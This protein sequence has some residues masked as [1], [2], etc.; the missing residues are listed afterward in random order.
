MIMSLH[1]GYVLVRTLGRAIRK[2]QRLKKGFKNFILLTLRYSNLGGLLHS[3]LHRCLQVIRALFFLRSLLQSAC[4]QA[5][6]D[7]A[8]IILWHN[9]SLRA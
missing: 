5:L 6:I 9:L 3:L 4:Y 1:L 2:K 7:C 8:N